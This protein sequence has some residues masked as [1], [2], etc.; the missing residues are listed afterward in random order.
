MA[1]HLFHARLRGRTG[2]QRRRGALHPH[3]E[4]GVHPSAHF[5]T[6]EEARAVIGAFIHRHSNGWILQRHGYMPP[7]RAREKLSREAA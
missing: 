5:E 2:A 6:L 1:R 3:P 7:A 4:G